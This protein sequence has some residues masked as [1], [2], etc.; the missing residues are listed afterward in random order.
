MRLVVWDSEKR[1]RMIDP[2]LEVEPNRSEQGHLVVGAVVCK[3]HVGILK[4]AHELKLVLVDVVVHTA[5]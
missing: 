4:P 2:V 3:V 5:V 1:V